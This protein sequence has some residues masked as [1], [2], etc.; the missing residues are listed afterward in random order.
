MFFIDFFLAFFN[1]HFIL[2]IYLIQGSGFRRRLLLVCYLYLFYLYKSYYY[3]FYYKPYV[4]FIYLTHLLSRFTKSFVV[5]TFCSLITFLRLLFFWY[6]LMVCCFFYLLLLTL[7]YSILFGN[8]IFPMCTLL[9]L[10]R[11]SVI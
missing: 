4:S 9:Y 2:L 3:S 10:F 1:I 8:D 5:F 6:I 11:N 7:G